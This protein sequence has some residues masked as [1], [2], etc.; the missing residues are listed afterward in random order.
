MFFERYF[1]AILGGVLIVTMVLM[2]TVVV[3]LGVQLPKST[4]ITAIRP[5][6]WVKII[7]WSTLLLGVFILFQ[8]LHKAKTGPRKDRADDSQS[9]LVD[10]KALI[11]RSAGVVA[12]IILLFLYYFLI[13]WLGM[14]VASIL[15][16]FAFSML[17]GER[18]FLIIIPLSVL[19][20]VGLYYFFLKVASVMVPLG[21][22]G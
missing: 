12:A 5:D 22:F 8:G 2:L 17:Y 15:V 18:R 16:M 19:I 13:Q 7:V 3:P 11:K 20:P 1:H 6:F 21:I 9:D 14:V 10:H 4:P